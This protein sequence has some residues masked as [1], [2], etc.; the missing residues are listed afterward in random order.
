MDVDIHGGK[1]ARVA[2][3]AMARTAQ[4][5]KQV[6]ALSLGDGRGAY[7]MRDE[8][9]ID[10]DDH[11]I[12]E[13]VV[14]AGGRIIR[15]NYDPEVPE[16]FRE[17]GLGRAEP[18]D[19]TELPRSVKVQFDDPPE[20]SDVDLSHVLERSELRT[21]RVEFSDPR[22]AALA[23][24]AAPMLAEGRGIWLNE[25]GVDHTLPLR[26]P[27]EQGGNTPLSWGVFTGRFRITDAWQLIETLR[28]ARSTSTPSF[29]AIVD[30]GFW[31][32]APTTPGSPGEQTIADLGVGAPRWNV[33]ND[34]GNVP[35]GPGRKSW[36]GTKVA[37][38][39]AAAIGN[40]MGAAGA[41]GSVARACYFHD[42]RSCDSAKLAMIRATQWGIP[43]V[44]YAGSFTSV[45]LFFGTSAWNRTFDW[46]ADN[47][48]I[49]FA[50]AGNDNIRL[51]DDSVLR[52]A[53][54]TPRV[55]TVGALNADGSKWKDSN[56]GS[57]VRI[58]APGVQ[59]PVVPTG[60]STGPGG[61]VV[62]G[63]SVAAPI[64]AGVAAMMRYANR[65]LTVDQIRD[66]LV[67]TGWQGTGGVSTGLDAHAA[68]WAA[69]EGRMA[70]VGAE[71]GPTLLVPRPD[72]TFAP[73]FAHVINR[74]GDTDEFL[75]DVPAYSHLTID[76]QWYERLSNL[77][78][79]LRNVD[80]DAP[81]VRAAV[82]RSP[83]RLEMSAT[84]GSGR[85]RITV[86]GSRP[87][88]YLLSGTLRR[89]TLTSDLFEPNDTFERATRLQVVKPDLA[90]VSLLGRRGPGTF[91]LTLHTWTGTTTRDVDVFDVWVPEDLGAVS[92]PVMRVT[93]DEPVDVTVFSEDRVEITSLPERR[94]ARLVLGPG[95][96][97][98]RVAG[99]VHTRYR[100][101]VG[102]EVNP[103]LFRPF[104][105]RHITFIPP[106]WDD[107]R[108]DWIHDI[109]DLRAIQLDERV[110]NDREL[111]FA[112]VGESVI[113]LLDGDGGVVREAVAVD[114]RVV[115]ETEGL[116]VG[117]Y[118]VRVVSATGS[119]VALQWEAGFG[120]R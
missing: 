28:I 54:R 74:P 73:P 98:V 57:S 6:G 8:L 66:L 64:V 11:E 2:R 16:S 48:T 82:T 59:I 61:W 24:F 30:S 91:E 65:S 92:V 94:D 89:G 83:G 81:E 34:N 109:D 1:G 106:W 7:F 115:I 96:T 44:V 52:P 4:I 97:Y 93:S 113:E 69:M 27:V 80:D 104:E 85:Y 63:T 35:T 39:A 15:E 49:M 78:L 22:S 29:V 114:G 110:L 105:E 40:M 79:E 102:T 17:I 71:I 47:G 87:T 18:A 62:D 32:D 116:E 90:Y 53:T 67:S 43:F 77:T 51:P 55:L 12:I 95:T 72:G 101:F 58:W 5:G 99:A 75:I 31:Y 42:D 76:L 88:A 37:S 118:A 21:D 100:L 13:R 86:R 120:L 119:P 19:S 56:H 38:A 111:V 117:P 20:A 33:V 68:V 3:L 10:A 60:D 108:P 50:S 23:A 25:V 107:P 103:I 26:N 9:V 70:E 84:V 14:A 36:H 45:E 46:A 41:G 112:G